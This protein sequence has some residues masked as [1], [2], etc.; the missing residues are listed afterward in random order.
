MS[1]I[2]ADKLKKKKIT[3]EPIVFVFSFFLQSSNMLRNAAACYC[4]TGAAG[5][6]SR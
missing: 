6:F 5:I 1:V 4:K 3:V 2:Q